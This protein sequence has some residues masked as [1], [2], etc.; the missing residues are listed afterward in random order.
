MIIKNMVVDSKRQNGIK[1]IA[2]LVKCV[3]SEYHEEGML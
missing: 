2:K 1:I 3:L